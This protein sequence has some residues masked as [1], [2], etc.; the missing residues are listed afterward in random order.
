[1]IE[2]AVLPW[3]RERLD[4]LAD[5]LAGAHAPITGDGKF[6]LEAG[7][8]A[9]RTALAIALI[10]WIASESPFDVQIILYEETNS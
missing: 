3:L 1:M 10:E 4:E 5:G 7:K 8:K 2:A 9:A 6:N